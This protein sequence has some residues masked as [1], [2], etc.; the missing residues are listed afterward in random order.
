MAMVTKEKIKSALKWLI[1]V[2]T[3]VLSYLGANS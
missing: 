3:L 1:R 2:A